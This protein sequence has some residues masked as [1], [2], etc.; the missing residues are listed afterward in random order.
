M[1]LKLN[2]L[3]PAVLLTLLAFPTH[4][5]DTKMSDYAAIEQTIFDYFDGLRHADRARLEKA[6]AVEAGHMKGYLKDDD[7]N[8]S[9]SSRP[10]DEVIDEWAQR[11]PSPDLSGRIVSLQIYADVAATVLFDFSG[12]FIDAFQLAKIDG[13]WRIINKFYINK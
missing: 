5:G 10:M 2:H 6:F 7:G 8:Y 13:Q 4:A 1:H 9:L 3:L 11:D 12:I